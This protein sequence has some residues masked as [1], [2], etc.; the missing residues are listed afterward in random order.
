MRLR[1]EILKYLPE[2]RLR[3][4]ADARHIGHT[5]AAVLHRRR[6]SEAAEGREDLR[7]ALVAAQAEAGGD[8]QR[9]LVSAMRHAAARRPAVLLQHVQ[10][11]Q[12]LDQAVGE[13]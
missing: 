4:E 3:L 5:D 13:G 9:E 12:V 7:V 2:C 8:V 11:P 6:V 10:R 1:S